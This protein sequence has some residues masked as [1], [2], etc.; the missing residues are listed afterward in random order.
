MLARNFKTASQLPETFFVQPKLDGV[1]CIA[2]SDGTL[3]SRNRKPLFV[4]HIADQVQKMDPLYPLDG[5]LY[6]H[7]LP[8]QDIQGRVSVQTDTKLKREIQYHIYD[9]ISD[10]PFRARKQYLPNRKTNKFLRRVH[11]Q[12]IRREDLEDCLDHFIDGG[13]EGIILR[14]DNFP[15]EHRRS[16]SLIKYK[17]FH[18][19]EFEIVD[20]KEGQGKNMGTPTYICTIKP[21]H[22]CNKYCFSVTAPGDYDEKRQQFNNIHKYI[23]RQLTVKYQEKTNAGIP[24]FPIALG[25]KED[26]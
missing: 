23:G 2:K 11:T 6:I 19:E 13:Y 9:T 5:E 22:A 17:R 8:F 3:L 25:F 24:R 14:L 18:D 16:Q 26:R 4:P 21:G 1:R 20:F 7:G 10:L 15:Y 12:I